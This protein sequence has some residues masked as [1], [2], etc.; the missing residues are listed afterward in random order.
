MDTP[1]KKSKFVEKRWGSETW[2]ANNEQHN[3]CGKI[4][5][6]KKDCYSSMH[7]H[8]EKHEVFYITDGILVVYTIDSTTG[9]IKKTLLNRGQRMEI[10]QGLAHQLVAWGDDVTFVEVS[11]F[12]RD[13]DSYRVQEDL[14][15]STRS[16][17]D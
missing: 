4:L 12:H 13:E 14:I 8:L 10:P 11:T 15:T 16:V 2:F 9:D 6:I 3:Y 17:T 1:S 7:Y 5:Y